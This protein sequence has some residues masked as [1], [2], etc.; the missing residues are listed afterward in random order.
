MRDPFTNIETTA[1]F[2][3]CWHRSKK[4]RV[5]A[6][7]DKDMAISGELNAMIRLLPLA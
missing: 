7:F 5:H 4:E 3:I 2:L 1:G 6:I